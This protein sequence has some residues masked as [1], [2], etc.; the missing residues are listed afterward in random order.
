[1]KGQ[2]GSSTAGSDRVYV[3][4]DHREVRQSLA[5]LLDTLGIAAWSFASAQ[6]F[7]DRV[8]SLPPAPLLLDI[9]MP[10]MSGIELLEVLAARQV[11]WPV[12]IMTG[13]NDAPLA[14]RA[15][16]LG[17]LR[18]LEKPF[19]AEILESAVRSALSAMAELDSGH[20]AA[21]NATA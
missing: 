18:V 3:I 21:A 10:G 17:A 6:E 1:M 19:S 14:Y 9:T 11:R 12:L 20:G 5:L 8:H 4:D 7:L 16:S 2:A 15:L 13:L